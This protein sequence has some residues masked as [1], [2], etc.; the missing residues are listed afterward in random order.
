MKRSPMR[1]RHVLAEEWLKGFY[2]RQM[3]ALRRVSLAALVA[4]V[5]PL[6]FAGPVSAA[7][8]DAAAETEAYD[9][10]KITTFAGA[11]LA[12]NN[13][14]VIGDRESAITLYRMALGFE[15]D[16]TD[17]KERLLLAY[18]TNGN[19]D[20]G[21]Q[22]AEDLKDDVN[23]ER[24]T[25][26]VRAIDA[27][28]KGKF[29]QAET[30][31]KYDGPNDL[32]RL[33]NGLLTAW[34]KVGRGDTKGALEGI[35]ALKGPAW[36]SIFKNYT[37]G[38]IAA[39]AN[40]RDTA[41]K[42][43]NDAVTDREGASTATDTF[44][45]AVIALANLEAAAGNQQKALDAISA[46]E[47]VLGN[48]SPLK[49]LRQ[50]IT[51][52]NPGAVTVGNSTE[53]AGTVLF[54]VAA[55]LN[56]TVSDNTA[57]SSGDD[58]IS[59]YL[60]MANVLAPKSGD[61]LVL[62]GGVAE[63]QKQQDK[64]IAYYRQVPDDSPLKRLSEL[65][66]GLAL[67]DSGKMEEARVHLKALVDADPTDMRSYL[68]YGSVLS[69][70]KDYAAMA[71]TYN[72]AVSQIGAAPNR[73]H[74]SIFYQRGIAFERLKQW[75]KAE[76]DFL[77]ALELNPD[78][79]QVLNYL[80]YSWV[81]MNINLEK[82]LG[83]IK[84]AVDLRPDDGYIVDSLG[85]AYYRLGQF[86]DAVK[87]LE[88][89]VELKESDATIN[90][91]LGDAYWRVGRKLEAGFQWN[92][93]LLAK[94]EPDEAAK[95]QEKLKSGLP[96]LT[97]ADMKKAEAAGKTVAEN[98]GSSNAVMAQAGETAPDAKASNATPD[99]SGDKAVHTVIEGD[100]LW[101]IAKEKLGNGM[102]FRAILDANPIL[103][104]NPDLLR[105]GQSL[106]LPKPNL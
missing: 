35:A 87:Q 24:V 8:A 12:G 38:L 27:A 36:F 77:K 88:R 53:G 81:D 69:E 21:A 1:G 62:L 96:E 67:S 15:P 25:V 86:E 19:L 51:S 70:G 34:A 76:P 58:V 54:S 11:Y 64:A 20:D 106:M 40:D 41:R 91:H 39:S 61:T 60:Q 79:P 7:T 85:W 105:P 48:Y 18:L 28:R 83:M 4:C 78:Q 50:S 97:D 32:D 99:M 102:L 72:Q 44:L 14:D 82:G 68:A 63:R 103:K 100:S 104:N 98:S 45:R 33:T 10:S 94:P 17:I 75:D 73:S 29:R 95:I 49:A 47:T 90:D 5:L 80:G 22:L 6:G 16:N 101:K 57:N 66:L 74:W 23:V 84:K 52:G 13:A 65:Q 30:I 89:A 56:Q 9:I 26:I 43:L 2:M 92:R 71:D 93:S 55:A 37:G 59:I 31:L 42:M 3:F 46:G